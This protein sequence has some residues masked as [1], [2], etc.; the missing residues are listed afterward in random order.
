MKVAIVGAGVSGLSLGYFLLTRN[1]KLQIT[2]FEKSSGFGGRMATRRIGHGITI[3]T[4]CQYL[5]FDQSEILEFLWRTVNSESIKPLPQPILCLP[6]GWIVDP[7]DRFYFPE[8]MNFW[9]RSIY[10]QLRLL[11]L[12]TEVRFDTR[13]DSCTQLYEQGFEQ[14]FVT[15]PGETAVK[16]GAQQSPEYQ[17]C[18]SLI[19][20]WNGSPRDAIEHFAYR[21][22]SQRE[23]VTW[24]A[25][26]GM[27]QNHPEIW[28]AQ[29]S[30]LKAQELHDA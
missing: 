13:I 26:E 24:L 23:G 7:Q 19:F 6:D 11:S 14:V 20:S 4:G 29:V 15:V 28:M 1:P 17:S 18:L 8:G 2:F 16:L 30:S 22:L 3:D 21:D 25:H 9:C 10:E 5:S 12:S 27:K